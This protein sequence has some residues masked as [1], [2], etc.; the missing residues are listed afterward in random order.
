MDRSMNGSLSKWIYWVNNRLVLF[1]ISKCNSD[2]KRRRYVNFCNKNITLHKY[3][4]FIRVKIKIGQFQKQKK[5]NHVVLF[6]FNIEINL[7]IVDR[8][9]CWGVMLCDVL[10]VDK[11]F[12]DRIALRPTY[13]GDNCGRQQQRYF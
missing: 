7:F 9:L 12:E 4:W 3:V 11:R 2:H 6:C 10:Y 5:T 8:Y 13:I 1:F